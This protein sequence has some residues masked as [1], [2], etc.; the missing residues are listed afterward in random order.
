MCAV[1]HYWIWGM[2]WSQQSRQVDK[3]YFSSYT[4]TT[5][6]EPLKEAASFLGKRKYCDM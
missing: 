1:K 3:L 5:F 4:V 6:S 2:I